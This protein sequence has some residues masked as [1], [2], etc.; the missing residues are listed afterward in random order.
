MLTMLSRLEKVKAAKGE[1]G[2][3]KAMEMPGMYGGSFAD[4]DGHIFE[5]I[6]MEGEC[7][8]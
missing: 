7:P 1:V 6:F 3:T 5:L 4:L 2:V 8:C